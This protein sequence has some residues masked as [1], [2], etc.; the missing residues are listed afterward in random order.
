MTRRS[1]P[2]FVPQPASPGRATGPVA[3]AVAG[4]AAGRVAVALA[5]LI[6]SATIGA[7]RVGAETA[8]PCEATATLATGRPDPALF[9]Y[10]ASRGV[11]AYWCETYDAEGVAHRAGPYWDLHPNGV[12]RVRASYVDSRIE[13]RVEVF[14][15]ESRL[16]LRGELAAGQWNGPLELFHSNGGRWLAAAFRAGALDGPVET[17]FPDGSLE[18]QTH[19]QDGREDGIA[20]SYYPAVAGGGLR[21]EVRVEGDRIVDRGPGKVPDERAPTEAMPDSLPMAVRE[22]SPR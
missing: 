16:W 2:T 19:F 9:A 15:E 17:W 10:E 14:D 4:V 21:T 7:A 18:S 20:T 13:G 8:H 6:A 3:G 22:P 11:Q 1:T 12:T 5:L